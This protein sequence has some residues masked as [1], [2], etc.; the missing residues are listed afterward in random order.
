MAIVPAAASEPYPSGAAGLHL[1]WTPELAQRLLGGLPLTVLGQ[2]ALDPPLGRLVVIGRSEPQLAA[3]IMPGASAGALAL[4]P[5]GLGPLAGTLTPPAELRQRFTSRQTSEAIFILD[6]AGNDR[7]VV[8]PGVVLNQLVVS[9]GSWP[10]LAP[11]FGPR[12]RARRVTSA[13]DPRTCGTSW[14]RS[15]PRS[16]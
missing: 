13:E 8:G 3:A 7:F 12:T 5:F 1:T 9:C 10:L 15:A 16:G 4:A 14:I 6:E 2:I 11:L